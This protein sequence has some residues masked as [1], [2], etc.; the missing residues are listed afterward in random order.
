MPFCPPRRRSTVTFRTAGAW[1][2]M[3]GCLAGS[4]AG[5]AV[6]RVTLDPVMA[7]ISYTVF[8]FGIL[9]IPATFDRFRGTIEQDMAHPGACRLQV[10][11]DVE[12]LHMADEQRRRQVLGPDMLDASQF[13]TMRFSGGCETATLTGTL[14]L[15]GVSRPLS[16]TMQRKGAEVNCVGTLVRRDFGILGMRALVGQKVRIRLSVHLPP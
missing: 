8:A 14:T 7:K 16:L 2:L 4:P 11:V 12:S 13:P 1:V 15:H 5:A 6:R 3:A 10:T 9:P